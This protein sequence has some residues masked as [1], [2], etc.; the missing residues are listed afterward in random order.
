MDIEDLDAFLTKKSNE[1]HSFLIKAL[2]LGFLGCVA[3]W[4]YFFDFSG[5]IHIP[6]VNIELPLLVASIVLTVLSVSF[7]V[8]MLLTI[9]QG[10]SYLIAS[11][12]QPAGSFVSIKDLLLRVVMRGPVL[13]SSLPAIITALLANAIIRIIFIHGVTWVIFY[14]ELVVAI[15]FPFLVM[16]KMLVFNFVI[17]MIISI[18][19]IIVAASVIHSVFFRP[20]N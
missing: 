17:Y 3:I 9:G 12:N 18:P 13:F 4:M 10:A 1:A 5:K 7:F 14:D 2:T 20:A 6:V 8:C 16:V 15:E 19:E 11:L